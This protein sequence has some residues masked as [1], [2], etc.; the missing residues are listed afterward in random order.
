MRKLSTQMIRRRLKMRKRRK[1]Q[2]DGLF[3]RIKQGFR[4]REQGGRKGFQENSMFTGINEQM[5][6]QEAGLKQITKATFILSFHNILQ[7]SCLGN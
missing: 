1:Q 7:L 5:P 3:K 6:N 4:R 2:V